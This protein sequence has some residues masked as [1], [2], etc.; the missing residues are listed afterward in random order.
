[1]WII[2]RCT[3]LIHTAQNTENIKA[4]YLRRDP[5]TIRRYKYTWLLQPCNITILKGPLK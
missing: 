2:T 5:A 4:N 1:M 3:L